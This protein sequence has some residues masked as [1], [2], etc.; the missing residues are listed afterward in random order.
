M[1]KIYLLLLFSIIAVFS[2]WVFKYYINID[3]WNDELITLNQFSFVPLEITIKWYPQPNNHIFFNII[4][5]V[6]LKFFNITNLFELLDSPYLIRILMLTYSLISIFVVFKIGKDFFNKETGILSALFLATSYPFFNFSV[7]VRGYILSIMLFSLLIYSLLNFEK[8]KVKKELFFISLYSFL[9]LYTIPSNL[10]FLISI[11][12]FYFLKIIFYQYKK[13]KLFNFLSYFKIK[14]S[15][16]L[17]AFLFSLIPTVIMY[18]LLGDQ[19]FINSQPYI[20]SVGFFNFQTLFEKMPRIILEFFSFRTLLFLSPLL[21]LFKKDFLISNKKYLF[22]F[23]SIFFLPF[24]FSFIRGDEPFERLFI[25]LISIFSLFFGIIIYD[26][27]NYFKLLKNKFYIF[28]FLLFIFCNV[29]FYLCRLNFYEQ[30]NN[31]SEDYSSLHYVGNFYNYF[32]GNF[33]VNNLLKEFLNTYNNNYPILG[34]LVDGEASKL[35]G[36]KYNLTIHNIVELKYV[37][38]DKFYVITPVVNYYTSFINSLNLGFNVEK[39]NNID[40]YYSILKVE[41]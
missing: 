7:Q 16:I 37:D 39:V 15:Y 5:N 27:I 12:T 11:G 30:V 18:S 23:L 1:N 14:Y 25:P 28:F 41:R 8:N 32:Q 3:F 36:L 9:L 13:H 26:F 20:K 2:I 4:N 38:L 17:L 35:Y 6:Y 10:Y 31:H 24:I 21:F 22:F 29:S 33:V 34:Y 40:S 19:L